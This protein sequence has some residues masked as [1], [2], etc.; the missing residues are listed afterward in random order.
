MADVIATVNALWD[1]I[2]LNNILIPACVWEAWNERMAGPLQ[3][4]RHLA[5]RKAD[6]PIVLKEANAINVYVN[7]LAKS[8]KGIRR[9]DGSGSC[10]MESTIVFHP[11]VKDLMAH[12]V[13]NGLYKIALLVDIDSEVNVSLPAE[14]RGQVMAYLD[15]IECFI[16][17][18]KGVTLP[19]GQ[20]A[21][22]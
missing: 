2:S 5:G 20:G 19:P 13:G 16:V 15:A 7:S 1:K 14:V 8:F 9:S 11:V 12:Y 10:L 17:R 4:I 18:I 21:I 22:K 6:R 3:E